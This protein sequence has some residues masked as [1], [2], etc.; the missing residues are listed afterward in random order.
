[1]ICILIT[2]MSGTGKSSIIQALSRRGFNAVDLDSPHWSEYDADGEWVWS[3][4]KVAELLTAQPANELFFVSGCARNQ[5]K[6]YPQFAHVILLSAPTPLIIERLQT[7]T[8]NDY[9]KTPEELAETLQNIQMIEPLL[10]KG[11][12]VELDTSISLDEVATK[13]LKFV[14]K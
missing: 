7:R 12:D 14:Q 13:I 10:R 6:F 1:M 5:G 4:G 8:N 9:G 11:A 2:G 3:E